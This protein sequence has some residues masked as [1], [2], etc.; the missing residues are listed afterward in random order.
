MREDPRSKTMRVLVDGLL[1][2]GDAFKAVPGGAMDAFFDGI[3]KAYDAVADNADLLAVM[4]DARKTPVL[5]DLEREHGIVPPVGATT[6]QRRKVLSAYQRRVPGYG[7]AQDLEEALRDLGV[8]AQVRA[9]EGLLDPSEFLD[10]DFACVCGAEDSCCGNESAYCGTTGGELI[11]TQEMF[12]RRLDRLECGDDDACCGH[13]DACCGFFDSTTSE[14]VDYV[15]PVMPDAWSKVFFV[16]GQFKNFCQLNDWHMDHAGVGAWKP[17]R[18]NTLEKKPLA[19]GDFD[20][21]NNLLVPGVFELEIRGVGDFFPPGLCYLNTADQALETPINGQTYISGVARGNY[22]C[23]PCVYYKPAA[24]NVW[25]LGW[26]PSPFMDPLAPTTFWV[27][28]PDG[29]SAIR[30][31]GRILADYGWV[32]CA[33]DDV[34]IVSTG[35]IQPVNIPTYLRH[36][37]IDTILRMK[38]ID[39]WC[40]LLAD[41][42]AEDRPTV[43][44]LHVSYDAATAAQCAFDV[45]LM[46]GYGITIS[47]GDGDSQRIEGRGAEQTLT[48]TYGGAAVY[49]VAITGDIDAITSIA[50][51]AGFVG[52][53]NRLNAPGLQSL[54]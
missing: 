28:C 50:F 9:N 32:A 40:V 52:T 7:S 20:Y 41:Y 53:T 5:S 18:G 49:P 42:V 30:L 39:T 12:N 26:E 2:N 48:H 43:I 17:G 33:F 37:A 44:A 34:R 10:Q 51:S 6:M 8:N 3:A 14:L 47:W 31:A 11:V 22:W 16:G 45:A 4:R 29:I 46:L 54:D 38:P 36:H 25:Y 15:V 21:A 35:E 13:E 1:P 19:M 23:R 27:D 24:E